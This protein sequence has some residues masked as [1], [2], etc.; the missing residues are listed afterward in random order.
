MQFTGELVRI[1]V[2]N[3]FDEFGTLLDL[4]RIP[5]EGI[6]GYRLRLLDVFNH[7]AGN[8]HRGLVYGMN[9]ELGMRYYDAG[10]ILRPR[11]RTDGQPVARDMSVEIKADGIRF[12]SSRFSS[13]R[14]THTVPTDT[15]TIKLN[16]DISSPDPYVEYNSER[17][18][19]RYYRV[20]EDLN[21]I[22]FHH[23]Y[24]GLEIQVTYQYAK[25]VPINQS[26]GD[27][28][29]D[30]NTLQLG[31][32]TGDAYIAIASLAQGC[33]TGDTGEGLAMLPRETVIGRR[34]THTG[35]Y[36][37]AVHCPWGQ[38]SVRALHDIDYVNANL[39]QYGTYFGTVLMRLVEAAKNVA[40]VTW[41]QMTFGYDRF[42]YMLGLSEIP[43]LLDARVGR[44]TCTNPAHTATYRPEE[45][46]S[47]RMR[48]PRDDY[49]MVLVGIGPKAMQSGVGGPDDLRMIVEESEYETVEPT[50]YDVVSVIN[51]TF[52][53]QTGDVENEM[54]QEGL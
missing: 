49:P 12:Y 8:Q 9:R 4:P 43:T 44:W 45:A 5:N 22:T 46:A 29:A 26:M 31:T 52:T 14:E 20:D 25:N 40:H 10:L 47:L 37:D 28:V 53:T 48:C 34:S 7:R 11:Q 18:A 19:R 41:D 2:P 39:N 21:E 54:Q 27:I 38:V 23:D 51:G 32:G 50:I 6:T 30:I 24:A 15:L 16:Y 17:I 3:H 42:N 1:E 33:S 35:D 36:Y 13:R